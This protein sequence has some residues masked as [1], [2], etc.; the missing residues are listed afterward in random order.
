MAEK[1]EVNKSEAIRNYYK[2]EPQ[3]QD[4]RRLSMPWRNKAS[5]SL[6][7]LSPT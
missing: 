3:G 7:A 1:P 5:R 6:S 4:P 2:I